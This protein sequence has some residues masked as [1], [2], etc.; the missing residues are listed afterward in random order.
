[1]Q[2]CFAVT[3]IHQVADKYLLNLQLEEHIISLIQNYTLLEW[4]EHLLVLI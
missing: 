1:M 2:V 4:V 3:K